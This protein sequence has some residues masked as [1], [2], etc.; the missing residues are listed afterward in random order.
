MGEPISSLLFKFFFY[1]SFSFLQ[2]HVADQHLHLSRTAGITMPS[3]TAQEALIRSTYAKAGLDLT[4]PHERCQFFEAH[5]TGTPA[6]DPI[7]AAAIR[8][9]F[10]ESENQTVQPDDKLYVGSVKT[11]IGHTEGTAGI[12]AVMKASLAIQN[13]VCE[14]TGEIP[15]RTPDSGTDPETYRPFRPIYS[16]IARALRLSRSTG[17]SRLP[18]RLALGLPCP[19]V[20]QG[21][22][23]STVLV[24]AS[25][26]ASISPHPPTHNDAYTSRND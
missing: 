20:N 19:M 12:A 15:W 26:T 1:S 18:P 10:F 5:G 6:G 21:E 24:S 3:S 23:A 17:T 2:L 8:Q 22:R 13:A 14:Q 4:K 25:S 16:S 7:E 9:A 11:V